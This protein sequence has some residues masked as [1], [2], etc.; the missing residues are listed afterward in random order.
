MVS[1]HRAAGARSWPWI[2][3]ATWSMVVACKPSASTI[4]MLPVAAAFDTTIF[5]AALYQGP[6]PPAVLAD[7]PWVQPVAGPVDAVTLRRNVDQVASLFLALQLQVNAGRFNAPAIEEILKLLPVVAAAELQM[8]QGTCN[9]ECLQAMH[10]FYLVV[11]QQYLSQGPFISVLQTLLGITA[12]QAGAQTLAVFQ[13]LGAAIRRAGPRHLYV[14][15]QLLKQPQLPERRRALLRGVIRPLRDNQRFD[16]A[17]AAV[18]EVVHG[19]DAA[20]LSLADTALVGATCY[21]AKQAACGDRAL[22]QLTTKVNP[23]WDQLDANAERNMLR[24]YKAALHVV[25]TTPNPSTPDAM[26]AVAKAEEELGYFDA[27]RARLAQAGQNFPSQARVWSRLAQLDAS[28]GDD[29]PAHIAELMAKAQRGTGQDAGYFGFRLMQLYQAKMSTVLQPFL[30]DPEN[31]IGLVRAALTELRALVESWAKVEPRGLVYLNAI[32]VVE[33]HLATLATTSDTL[34]AEMFAM[35]KAL[36]AK[37]PNDIEITNGAG[38]AARFE[39]GTPW[40]TGFLAA[41]TRLHATEPGLKLDVQ[42][43]GTMAVA[44]LVDRNS[45]QVAA[46]LTRLKTLQQTAVELAM[47]KELNILHELELVVRIAALRLVPSRPD[48][49]AALWRA[50]AT[51]YQAHANGETDAK[52]APS[53]WNNAA[54]AAWAAGDQ[55]GARAALTKLSQVDNITAKYNV[56]VMNNNQDE[57][58]RIAAIT[59]SADSE[60]VVIRAAAR[61]V[62]KGPLP[63]VLAGT[64]RPG[65]KVRRLDGELG[66]VGDEAFEMGLGYSSRY[67]VNA[68]LSLTFVGWLLIDAAPIK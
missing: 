21:A 32:N 4:R 60:W 10:G 35:I 18:N 15:A 48:E 55:V 9:D 51:Y 19:I 11:D 64:T 16:L 62:I 37:F 54:V 67:G 58:R 24:E 49:S 46:L 28:H 59:A 13:D 38:F 36:Y 30:A 66:I 63:A 1:N 14:V 65:S 47:R 40:S 27:A 22:A 61:R 7:L 31:S 17:S 57:L 8:S 52:H 12:G 68:P 26:L 6:V 20:N 34:V 50:A 3:A 39:L 33:P 53:L 41:Q 43:S 23:T 29:S 5:A 56:A 44:A 2:I 25:V 45:K 42:T